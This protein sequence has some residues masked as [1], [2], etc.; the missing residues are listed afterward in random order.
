MTQCCIY[1]SNMTDFL[2]MRHCAGMEERSQ[3]PSGPGSPSKLTAMQEHE[4]RR[5]SQSID[6]GPG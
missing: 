4:A 5:R 2:V 6:R 1:V 3:D